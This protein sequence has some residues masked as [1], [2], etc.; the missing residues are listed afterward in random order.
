MQVTT[1]SAS[2]RQF[3]RRLAS[4][5]PFQSDWDI[6]AFAIFFIFIGKCGAKLA[7]LNMLVDTHTSSCCTPILRSKVGIDNL[8]MEP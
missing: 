7:V 6:A 2:W 3:L 8:G 5:N 4:K 1:Q